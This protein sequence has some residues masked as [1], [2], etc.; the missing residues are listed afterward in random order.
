MSLSVA[1][2]SLQSTVDGFKHGTSEQPK[3]GTSEWYLL[4]GAVI[5]LAYL[6]RLERLGLDNDPPAADR[7]Y[8]EAAK[9]FK[10][11]EA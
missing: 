9:V 7:V 11:A 2:T 3:D 5:G 4:R 6:K 8:R 1:I 10:A